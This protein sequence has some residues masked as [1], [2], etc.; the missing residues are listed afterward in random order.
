MVR[1][2]GNAL[3]AAAALSGVDHRNAVCYRDRIITTNR[4]AVAVSSTAETALA[5]AVVELLNSGAGLCS[6]KDKSVLSRFFT[7]ITTHIGYLTDKLS[8]LSAHYRV[9]L[10]HDLCAAGP[11]KVSL[12]SQHL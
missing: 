2:G 3:S 1:T 10:L 4:C 9:Y 12:Y 8:A 5:L 11:T 6:R 7:A